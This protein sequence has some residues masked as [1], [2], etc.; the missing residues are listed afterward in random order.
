[1]ACLTDHKK[2]PSR[3][4]NFTMETDTSSDQEIQ[5]A[6]FSI[7]ATS[8]R[9]STPSNDSTDEQT[10]A[11]FPFKM[12]DLL[13]DAKRKKFDDIVSWVPSGKAFKIHNRLSFEKLIMP[14]YFPKM[15]SYKSFRRQLNS[16]G[17]YQNRGLCHFPDNGTSTSLIA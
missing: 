14:L 7:C 10:A 12:Y 3:R 4:Y 16:Y 17:I 1:M 5:T 13:E 6:D 2:F 11:I 8:V 9:V 15:N